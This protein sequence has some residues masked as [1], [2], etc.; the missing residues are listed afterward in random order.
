MKAR[1]LFH[2]WITFWRKRP[3]LSLSLHLFVL[4]LMGSQCILGPRPILCSYKDRVYVFY[5]SQNPPVGSELQTALSERDLKWQSIPYDW[6]I[7]P[8][9]VSDPYQTNMLHSWQ[10]PSFKSEG[11][12][13]VLGSY[14]L[15][16]SVG[17]NLLYGFRKS[18]F[19]AICS[20]LLGCLVGIPVAAVMAY[21]H[22]E[23]IHTSLPVFLFWIIGIVICIWIIVVMIHHQQ[24]FWPALWVPVF[25]FLLYLPIA[26]LKMNLKKRINWNPDSYLSAGIGLTKSFPSLFLLLFLV[27]WVTT[28]N[29][30][31]I[32]FVFGFFIAVSMARYARFL[33]IR[34]SSKQWVESLKALGLSHRRIIFI[35][36]IPYLVQSLFPLAAMSLGSVV[37]SESTLTFLGLGL[38]IGEISLGNMMHSARNFP[39]AWWVLLFPGLAVFWMVFSFY[40]W[41]Q[42]YTHEERIDWQTNH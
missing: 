28:P 32:V 41:G 39:T 10:K 12:I 38:P 30:V 3:W 24:V 2:S 42:E 6:A 27:N 25:L 14:D 20:V 11:P 1:A 9:I 7:W 34:E 17:S 36:L 37:L 35:H 5:W 19:L 15:G 8:L 31:F 4:I 16:R 33:M 40:R 22:K 23:G 21:Y 26:K 18:L 29:T 13:Y